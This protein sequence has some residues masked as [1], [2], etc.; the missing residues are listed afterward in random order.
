M[1]IL[2]YGITM[3]LKRDNYQNV[4]IRPCRE[5]ILERRKEQEKKKIAEFE[6]II[7]DRG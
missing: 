3:M 4:T 1:A 5:I 6:E 7:M 2:I